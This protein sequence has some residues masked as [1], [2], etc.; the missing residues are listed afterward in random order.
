MRQKLETKNKKKSD[1][2]VGH[3]NGN[4]SLVTAHTI[5]VDS[6]VYNQIYKNLGYKD[7]P[8]AY[9]RKL[10]KLELK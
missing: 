9:L 1:T 2:L 5:R 6:E 7:S 8:N 3:S 4:K 10:M